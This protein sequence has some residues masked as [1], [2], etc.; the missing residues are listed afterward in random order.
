[1]NI[2]LSLETLERLFMYKESIKKVETMMDLRYHKNE[3]EDEINKLDKASQAIND[4][5]YELSESL[6]EDL[7]KKYSNDL[8]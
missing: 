7:L 4:I 5:A 8:E 6:L 3:I 1:M 2:D